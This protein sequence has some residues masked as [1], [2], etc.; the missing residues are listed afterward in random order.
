[1]EL[2][3]YDTIN[4]VE[5]PVEFNI[6]YTLAGD[7]FH[8]SARLYIINIEKLNSFLLHICIPPFARSDKT[9]EFF[10]TSTYFFPEYQ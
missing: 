7:I 2:K 8:L 6:L 1:M 5:N 3:Q 4:S 9:E 10:L